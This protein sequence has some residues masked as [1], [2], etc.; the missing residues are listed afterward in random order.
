[1]GT[2]STF[3]ANAQASQTTLSRSKAFERPA[4]VD[5]DLVRIEERHPMADATS[6]DGVRLG[7][8]LLALAS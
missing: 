1:M 8:E 5:W 3:V 4:S 2:D 7:H 6:G